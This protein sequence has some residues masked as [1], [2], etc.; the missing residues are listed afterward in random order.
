MKNTHYE[1]TFIID[2][3]IPDT[4]HSNI[5]KNIKDLLLKH[6]AEIISEVELGKKKLNYPIKKSLKGNYFSFEFNIDA[7]KIK[8]IEN[9]MRLE[10]RILRALTIKKPANAINKPSDKDKMEA[11]DISSDRDDRK[12]DKKIKKDSRIE[13]APEHKEEIKK[14]EKVETKEEVSEPK[15]EVKEEPVSAKEESNKDELDE[16]L[17]AILNKDEF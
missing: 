17:D 5:T 9:E 1:L 6:E 3:N 2:G 8:L 4:E 7:S 10:N 16:K 14:E 12:N 13:K 15:P 11:R